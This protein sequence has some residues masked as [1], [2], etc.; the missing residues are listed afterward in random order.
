MLKILLIVTLKI[1]MLFAQ[2]LPEVVTRTLQD[3][4]SG[5]IRFMI[6]QFAL[7]RMSLLGDIP[8]KQLVME[9]VM[10]YKRWLKPYWLYEKKE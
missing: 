2:V 7:K 3:I 9:R 8:E 6:M 10:Q 5:K 4:Y 1:W